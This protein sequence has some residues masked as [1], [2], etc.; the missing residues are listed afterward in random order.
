[1]KVIS[2]NAKF[3]TTRR[4]I[5]KQSDI[6][7]HLDNK[8]LQN[9]L[10][11]PPNPQRK[12]E[13]GLRKMEYFK[14][15][16]RVI[17]VINLEEEL[18]DIKSL[19][20]TSATSDNN[21]DFK[22]N[23]S[24]FPLVTIITVVFNSE[25]YIEQT[26]HSVINQTYNNVEYIIIDG[27]S[28]DGTVNIIQKYENLIDYWISEPDQGISDAFNKG[29]SVST[30]D[31]IG[32]INS[33]DWYEKNAIEIV[34]NHI[35]INT[36]EVVS[37]AINCWNFDKS[38]QEYVF[39]YKKYGNQELLLKGM[40]LNHPSCFITYDTYQQ[41]GLFLNEYQ[42][43]MDYELI[44]RFFVQKV[45]FITLQKT[46]ANMDLEG[47]STLNWI[48]AHQEVAQIKTRFLGNKTKNYL[49]FYWCIVRYSA[50]VFLKKIKLDL[51]VNLYQKY[52]SLNKKSK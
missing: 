12:G 15:S 44:L 45:K 3:S 6:A 31:V 11:L 23:S 20:N 1:M 28:T 21:L 26:I 48:D 30:G 50:Y 52:F 34:I 39:L 37:G 2:L 7:N 24:N 35:N 40:T 46:L 27:G 22:L 8:Q 47:K 10:F 5:N 18:A 19:T 36:Y 9:L 13:G 17:K 4:V 41:Y 33:G 43:A 29:I 42:L 32:I 14:C 49:Y 25:K 16:Q 38:R 51:I